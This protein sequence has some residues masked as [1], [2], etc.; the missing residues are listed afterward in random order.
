M[1]EVRASQLHIEFMMAETRFK[2]GGLP[3]FEA[4]SLWTLSYTSAVYYTNSQP[5][6]GNESLILCKTLCVCFDLCLFYII[7]KRMV[8]LLLHQSTYGLV[9]RGEKLIKICIPFYE[10]IHL[11]L[12]IGLKK[13]IWVWVVGHWSSSHATPIQHGITYLLLLRLAEGV[14]GWGHSGL[15][16]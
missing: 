14:R 16:P 7:F 4:L 11:H 8:Q 9:V 5:W 1:P 10:H 12:L 15:P 6:S 3:D 13:C 2:P